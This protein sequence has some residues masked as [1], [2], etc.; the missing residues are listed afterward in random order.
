MKEK[1]DVV[2]C[3]FL[4]W[5]KAVKPNYINCFCILFLSLSLPSSFRFIFYLFFLT[6]KIPTTILTIRI[7]RET[8]LKYVSVCVYFLN[9]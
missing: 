8:L 3:G 1:K 2:I 7:E 5:M 9:K 4:S 6:L